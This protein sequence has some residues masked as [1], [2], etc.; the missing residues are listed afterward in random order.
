[1]T[2]RPVRIRDLY[3]TANDAEDMLAASI[4]DAL[5]LY[6]HFQLGTRV[7]WRRRE[8]GRIHFLGV[9]DGGLAAKESTC[10]RP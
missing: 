10:K 7:A 9:I 5:G 8:D 4:A 6:P 3:A 2:C 1:M